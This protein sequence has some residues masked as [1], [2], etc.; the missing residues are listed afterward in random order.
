MC[1]L[2]SNGSLTAIAGLPDR[3]HCLDE[4]AYVGGPH[5]YDPGK[6]MAPVS[7][8]PIRVQN[9][10]TDNYQWNVP[11]VSMGNP[12]FTPTFTPMA[13]LY[14]PTSTRTDLSNMGLTNNAAYHAHDNHCQH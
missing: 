7:L 6:K 4:V 13:A 14:Q 10:N 1:N 9:R 3:D 12:V 8:Q 5:S 2:E 11:S